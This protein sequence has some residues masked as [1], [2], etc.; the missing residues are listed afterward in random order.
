MIIFEPRPKHR[1]ILTEINSLIK[2]S[3]L[4]KIYSFIFQTV[5]DI[6]D[7]H[8]CTTYRYV[9]Q[10]LRKKAWNY[11]KKGKDDRDFSFSTLSRVNSN[12]YLSITEHLVNLGKYGKTVNETVSENYLPK[13]YHAFNAFNDSITA[14]YTTIDPNEMQVPEND[15]IAKLSTPFRDQI[16]KLWKESLQLTK[17]NKE[18]IYQHWNINHVIKCDLDHFSN[19][20]NDWKNSLEKLAFQFDLKVEDLFHSDNRYVIDELEKLNDKSLLQWTNSKGA[21][22]ECILSLSLLIPHFCTI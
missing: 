21:T 20:F 17:L 12:F 11:A 22:K 4:E 10:I 8:F 16:R 7:Y 19:I 18:N 9:V 13:V 14:I 1:L 5:D 2:I 15:G 6:S 3:S